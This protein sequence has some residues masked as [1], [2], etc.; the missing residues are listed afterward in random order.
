MATQRAELPR[1]KIP[2]DGT[3]ADYQPLEHDRGSLLTV[4]PLRSWRPGNLR[5]FSEAALT[6][7]ITLD[8]PIEMAPT[9][10]GSGP[11]ARPGWAPC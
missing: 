8:P 4:E 10:E 7:T 6:A 3:G 9:S 2:I 1:A 5:R 11:S